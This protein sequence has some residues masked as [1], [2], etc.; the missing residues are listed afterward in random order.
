MIERP[1]RQAAKVEI[2]NRVRAVRGKIDGLIKMTSGAR[3]RISAGE[4]KSK[5]K[6]GNATFRISEMLKVASGTI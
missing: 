1:A 2:G 5:I 3:L 4:A 6:A